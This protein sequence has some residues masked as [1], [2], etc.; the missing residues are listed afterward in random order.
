MFARS[1]ILGIGLNRKGRSPMKRCLR[2][3]LIVLILLASSNL[4][5]AGGTHI[6][7]SKGQ[8]VAVSV[9]WPK[10]VEE[11]VNDPTRTTGWHSTFCQWPNDVNHYAFEIATTDDLNRLIE[12]LAAVKETVSHHRRPSD[13]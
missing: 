9:A 1:L 4:F 8:P 5:A 3:G 7:A 12:K 13:A 2:A 11:L 6:I 10:G